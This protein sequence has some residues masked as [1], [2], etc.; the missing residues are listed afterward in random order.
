MSLNKLLEKKL[1]E[2]EEE[3]EEISTTG[4]GEAYNTKYAFGDLD[5]DDVEKSGYKKVKESK[6]RKMASA[7]FLNEVSYNE[8]KKNNDFSAKQKV[9]KSIKEVSSK[10]FRIERIINQNIKL[11]TEEGIDNKQYWKS[12]RNNLYKISERMMRI[13]EKLR[14]F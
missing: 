8:Y 14:K 3:L 10:L 4:A 9:N 7:S 5:D 6:F 13:G 11:K 12:T 2:V 1:K